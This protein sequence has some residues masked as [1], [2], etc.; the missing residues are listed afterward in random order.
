MDKGNTACITYCGFLGLWCGGKHTL[1]HRG[2]QLSTVCFI[3]RAA[4]DGPGT[5]EALFSFIFPSLG[6]L[7]RRVGA[8]IGQ[9]ALVQVAILKLSWPFCCNKILFVVIVLFLR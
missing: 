1:L 4:A 7:R 8:N 2:S 9:S 5:I 6:P 3:A